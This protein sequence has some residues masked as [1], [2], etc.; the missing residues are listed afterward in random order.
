[1]GELCVVTGGDSGTGSGVMPP[2][3]NIDK[4][5]VSCTAQPFTVG[6]TVSGLAPGAIVHLLDNG[7]D[8]Q[9]VSVDG[10]FTFTPQVLS[11]SAYAVTVET[12]PTT[13]PQTCLVTGGDSGTGSGTVQGSD[14]SVTVTCATD[15][16]TVGGTISGL[17]G[18]GLVLQNNGGDPTTVSTNDLLFPLFALATPV[19]SGKPYAVTV[20]TQPT[21]PSQTCVPAN[22]TG[23][24]TNAPITN[25]TV[26]CTTDT[27]TIGVSLTGL[28]SGVS[29][30]LQ[31]NDPNNQLQL[32]ANSPPLFNFAAPV[33][34]G[35]TYAVTVLTQP[36]NGQDCQVANGNGMVAGTNV[37]NVTVDC[38]PTA[39]LIGGTVSNLTGLGFLLHLQLPNNVGED[40]TVQASDTAFQFTTSVADNHLYQVTVLQNPNG[41]NC[42]V[43]GGSP[44][45]VS[46][47]DVN[48]VQ[49]TC[50]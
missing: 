4:V 45:I 48:S 40:L 3:P 26:T 19:L 39:Y 21:N 32:S 11:G 7:T 14:V 20:R 37:T 15:S 29:V 28:G 31:N 23:H 33:A 2:G 24:V 42:M 27:H 25:V 44:G 9:Q 5:Q 8:R 35:S 17:V 18:S 34:S 38:T 13:P 50:N 36:T 49:V 12:N 16:F 41:P 1:V 46:G 30:V 22:N 10:P 6:G 43:T 47:A